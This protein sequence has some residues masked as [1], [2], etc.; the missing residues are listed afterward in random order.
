MA[1]NDTETKGKL[2]KTGGKLEEGAGRMT[3]DHSLEARGKKRQ[4][5]GEAQKQSGRMKRWWNNLLDYL[6]A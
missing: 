6:R 3:A 4:M 1:H 5:K 2:N